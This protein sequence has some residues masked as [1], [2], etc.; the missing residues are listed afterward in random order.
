MFLFRKKIGGR[1]K[2]GNLELAGVLGSHSSK[3][4]PRIMAARERALA[5]SHVYLTPL[6][7]KK[8]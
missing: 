8:D 6:K 4:F 1:K 7:S 2:R 3:Q 5:A